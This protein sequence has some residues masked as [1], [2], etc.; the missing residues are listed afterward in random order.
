MILGR[1]RDPGRAVAIQE[2]KRRALKLLSTSEED[3]VMVNELACTEPGCPPVE[4]VIALLRA[5]QPPMSLKIHKPAREVSDQDIRDA[6]EHPH[7]Q[8]RT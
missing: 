1:S 2:L 4:T 8:A 7:E 3:T 6:L 5:G